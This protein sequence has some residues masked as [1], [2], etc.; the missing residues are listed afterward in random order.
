[1]QGSDLVVAPAVL[2]SR[3][4]LTPC[5]ANDWR[6]TS[7]P[8]GVLH[9]FELELINKTPVKSSWKLRRIFTGT[10]LLNGVRCRKEAAFA[11]R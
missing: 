11:E 10:F 3:L 8:C 5:T 7:N 9:S 6:G 4:I 1:M 2:C